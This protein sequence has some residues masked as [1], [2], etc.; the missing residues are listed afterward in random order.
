[1]TLSAF[2]ISLFAQSI[3]H[4]L[5]RGFYALYD[6]KAP[7]GAGVIAIIINTVLS[8]IFIKTL[9]LPIWSLGLSTSIAS[10]VNA[11]L[12]LKLLDA[13][14]NR[15]SRWDLF[16]PPIKMAI[17]AAITGVALYVP[18]KLLDQ[19]VFD[20]T[21]T[22]G[23]LL[24]TGVSGSI[25]LATY[26]FLSWVMGVGEVRFFFNLLRRVKRLRILLEP[27]GEASKRGEE[28]EK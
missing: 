4:V 15:F 1:M 11:G 23:L 8:I 7:V 5:A 14:V 12:L 9:A 22:F 21:R 20:T 3:S 18:L 25:G 27:A 24:L 16:G 17:A 28:G 19:L 10:F 2:S 6:T 13:R 26:L